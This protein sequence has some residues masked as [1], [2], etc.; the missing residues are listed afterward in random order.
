M[1]QKQKDINMFCDV[2]ENHRIMC[3]SSIAHV[4]RLMVTTRSELNVNFHTLVKLEISNNHHVFLG[5]LS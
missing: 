1:K 2:K 3:L 5:W 4:Y